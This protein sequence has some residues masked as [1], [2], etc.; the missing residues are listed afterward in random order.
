MKDVTFRE[1]LAYYWPHVV[2]YKWPTILGLTT[3]A[4]GGVLDAAIKPLLYKKLIDTTALEVNAASLETLALT[5]FGVAVVILTY[6]ILF[7][8]ADFAHTYAQSNIM[9]HLTD[10]SFARV[11][12]HSQEFFSNTFVGA[13][14]AK[15]KRYTDSFEALHDAF[16]FNILMNGLTLVVTFGILLWIAPL[17]GSIFIVWLAVYVVITVWFL[18][19]KIPKDIAHATS[20]SRTTGAL[21]DAISNILTVKMFARAKSEEETFADITKDQEIKRRNTWNWDT[22][23]RMFQGLAVGIVE[24]AVIVGAVVLWSR[25]EITPGT[26]VLVQLYLISLFNITWT[27]GRQIARIVQALNDAKE[28][29]EIFKTPP[30]VADT[31]HP[32]PVRIT[33]GEIRFENVVFKY[34]GNKP[35]FKGLS[36]HI[37]AGEKVG[38]VGHS[39]AGKSTITKLILRFTDIESG[40]ITIDGQDVTRVLQDD[41]RRSIA[42][43]P[44]EPVLFHRSLRENIAY[45]KPNATEEEVISAARRAHAHDFIMNLPKGYD[46]LVGERGI[47]LSGGERQRIA[48]ARAMLKDAPVLILDEATSS[49]DSISERHIQDA[50]TELMKGRTTLVIAHRLS[51]VQYMDRILV[52]SEGA[53]IEDGTHTEL[54]AKRDGTYR[55]L[56][57]EQSGGFL[58][59]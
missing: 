57:D 8:I 7:R 21:A 17:L 32:E 50:L 1:I 5:L 18:R 30:S 13:L 22:W 41:L 6:N 48:I 20:Q 35:V 59:E 40:R 39:G 45:G 52:F 58:G 31:E 55:E 4:V 54:I 56:W 43:V 26:I 49:L 14:V 33:K 47:K 2:V 42:Y 10:E 12:D 15:V 27:L 51:T 16:A 24:I 9:K 28:M 34:T 23:Q 29:I 37:P 46:T 44:Q 25:G 3:F 19:R 11:A 38:L 36:L 53:V